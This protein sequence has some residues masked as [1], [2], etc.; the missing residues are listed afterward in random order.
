MG[1]GTNSGGSSGSGG[2]MGTGSGGRVGT[3]GVG[4][5]GGRT[6]GSGVSASGGAAGSGQ[7]GMGPLTC[8]AGKHACAGACVDNTA[9]ATC[10]QSCSPCTAPQGGTATCDGTSCGF[11]CGGATPKKCAA[12]NICIAMS[13]CCTNA[14]CP[15]NAG[16]QTGTCDTGTH[17]CSYACP[18]G[19]TSCTAGGTTTCIPSTGCCTNMDCTGSCMACNTTT[20]TCAAVKGMD[21]PTGRCAGTCDA[22]GVCKAKQGQSCTAATQCVTGNCADGVCCNSACSG[23][24]EFCNGT[25]PGT[26]SFVSGAPRAGHP[27]CGGTGTC[28]GTCD[29]TKAACKMPGAETA[30]RA[31][32]CSNGTQTNAATCNGAGTCPASTTTPCGNYTCNGTTTCNTSCTNV[33]QCVANTICNAPSCLKCQ[34]GENVCANGCYKTDTDPNH[35]GATCK[36]CA[37]PTPSCAA[38]VCKCRQPSASNILKNPGFDGSIANWTGLGIY[39]KDNDAEG[40]TGS[41]SVEIVQFFDTF[42]QCFNSGFDPGTTYTF[43]FLYKG[44]GGTS[45]CHIAAFSASGCDVLDRIGASDAGAVVS[46][47]TSWVPGSVSWLVPSNAVSMEVM[48]SGVS[49]A[50]YFDH[51]SLSQGTR[52]PY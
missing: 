39:N 43:G 12:A 6:G 23:S 13:G 8:G 33:N 9:V 2:G 50:G 7:G 32:S 1:P 45:D 40:C 22:G 27:A 24:C 44:N 36:V 37:L 28:A 48:C 52:A 49:G 35:C 31:A 4:G 3:G 18:A 42:R 29:G 47:G 5:S 14:D 10:G 34:A 26:C 15:T 38:G 17:M 46:N 20:R 16:G 25:T 51:L 30:C 41:G 19:T 21:D 11:T